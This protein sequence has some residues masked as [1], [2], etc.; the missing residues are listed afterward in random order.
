MECG[1]H[2]NA[3]PMKQIAR[4]KNLGAP[5]A[6]HQRWNPPRNPPP[7][8]AAHP[9]VRCDAKNGTPRRRSVGGHPSTQQPSSYHI[10]S[11]KTDISIHMRSTSSS[12]SIHFNNILQTLSLSSQHFQFISLHASPFGGPPAHPGPPLPFFRIYTL[13]APHFAASGARHPF[14]FLAIPRFCNLLRNLSST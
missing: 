13:S 4:Q 12:V 2:R 7:E 14:F 3:A 6:G 11:Q 1:T 9:K 5:I 8:C 10:F